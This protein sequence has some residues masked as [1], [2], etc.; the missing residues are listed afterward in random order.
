MNLFEKVREFLKDASFYG[1][2]QVLSN[3]VGFLLIPIYTQFLSPADYG[4]MTL[5]GFYSLFFSPLSHLGLQGAMFRYVGFSKTKEEEEQI[6]STAFKVSSGIALLFTVIALML[7]NQIETLLLNSTK[8][9]KLLYYVI[10]SS[11]F[12]SV[13]E[14]GF[15]YLRIKRKVKTIFQLNII[16]L[17]F[18]V[19]LNIYLIVLRGWGLE[20][21]I[22]TLLVSSILSF[23][24]VIHYVK[25]P[26]KIKIDKENLKK[27]LIYGLPNVP[28][29]LQASI[30]MVFGQYILSRLMSANDLG[31]YAIAWKF[32]L[33]LQMVIGIF[34]NSWKAYK[35]ELLKNS[36]GDKSVLSK[37]TSLMVAGYCIIYLVVALWCPDL[38][39]IFTGANFHAAAQFVPY[40]ALIPLANAL[41]FVLGS[42]VSFGKTQML[43]PFIATAG[44]VLTVSLSFILI[45]EFSIKGA[46]FATTIGWV[47]M[48]VLAYLYGQ[49]LFKVNFRIN[50]IVPFIFSVTI[51]GI[52]AIEVSSSI[53]SRI[54]F[55][56]LNLIFILY[57]LSDTI[58]LKYLKV[59]PH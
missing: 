41:Y 25:I 56:C 47:V 27:M 43:Q 33:P 35:F 52:F 7:S 11:L 28:N 20:G 51:T 48:G 59:K 4:V 12:S 44:M 32:S 45:P 10:I 15:S 1:L 39:I 26:I 14:M 16:N 34:H 38:L 49:H 46:A 36:D 13:S 55:F 17:L 31:L 53:G 5:L 23:I 2:S 30:M 29:Y 19:S 18:S 50:K 54:V 37:F 24:L 42:F 8:Y 40:L 57:S 22:T 3:L 6:L 9:T 21:A 58:K